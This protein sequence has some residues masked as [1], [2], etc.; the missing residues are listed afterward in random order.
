MAIQPRAQ[1][2]G[3]SCQ[4][5]Q[6]GAAIGWSSWEGGEYHHA[7]GSTSRAVSLVIVRLAGTASRLAFVDPVAMDTVKATAGGPD[8]VTITSSHSSL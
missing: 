5:E 2:S 6:R 3:D 4:E 1:T 7:A 8:D